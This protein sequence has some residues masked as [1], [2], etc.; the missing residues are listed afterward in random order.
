[1]HT[2]TTDA[3]T[4]PTADTG[5]HHPTPPVDT[6]AHHATPPVDTK[7]GPVAAGRHWTGITGDD[8]WL[9]RARAIST[10]LAERA[11]EHD[12]AG[13]FVQD[14]FDLLREHGLLAML[15]PAELGG[16][17]ASHAQACATLAE[18][19]RGCPSTALS[20]SM[21]SHLVAAQVWRHHRGLPAPVLR[22]VVDERLVLISTGASD[23][24]DSSGT[25]TPVEGGFRISAR[26]MPASGCPAGD[27]LV[28]SVRWDDAPDGPQVVHCSV[29][30]ADAGVEIIES[31][32]TMG[33][34]GTGS[35]TVVIEDV[36]VP[37]AAIA[38]I[39]PA[40]V[41][42]PIW[43]TVVGAALPLIM[44]CYVGVAE[45]AVARVLRLAA[46]RADRPETAQLVGRMHNRLTGA[47]DAVRSMIDAGEDL[48]FDNTVEAAAAALTR[49]SNAAEACID[50]VRLA[51]EIGGGPAYSRGPG[52]ERLFRDVHGAL[53]HPL[54]TAQQERLSGRL[55][56][57]LD[58]L[59]AP[60]H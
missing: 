47:Q 22:R 30:F 17:G 39:R 58:P 57:A 31:W 19:A 6:G 40:D 49:K 60:S 41:W 42:H 12:R 35:H 46:R 3:A 59:G 38:L 23:W 2:I 20:F 16:G 5:A 36:F 8:P 26:K 24:L 18:L 54:P 55:A 53:Y 9:V 43:S 34:R 27:I 56:L 13:S 51:L 21:H 28:T 52:I 44:A 37:T 32:D 4:T 25:A 11:V 7:V 1:M 33:M 45:E 48:R 14:G 10:C 15:V 29:P 50:T